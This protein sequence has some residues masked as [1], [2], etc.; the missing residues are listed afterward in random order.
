MTLTHQAPSPQPLSHGAPPCN[1]GALDT[2]KDHENLGTLSV[3]WISATVHGLDAAKGI[4]DFWQSLTGENLDSLPNT[5]GLLGYDFSRRSAL[6]VKYL[7]SLK[8]SDRHFQFTQSSIELIDCEQQRELLACLVGFNAKFTRLDLCVDD[9]SGTLSE[10]RLSKAFNSNNYRSRSQNFQYI[11]SATKDYTGFTFYVGSRS[12][13]SFL[14]IYDKAF[15]S[16]LDFQCTRVEAEL[17]GNQANTQVKL[18]LQVPSCHWNELFIGIIRSIVDFV[19]ISFD[20]NKSRCPLLSWWHKFCGDAMK[21]RLT[22]KKEIPSIEPILDWVSKQFGSTI[23]FFKQYFGEDEAYYL[24]DT[25]SESFKGRL[26][27]RQKFILET[28]PG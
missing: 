6:G 3:S 18:L 4:I 20:T 19:D 17:K 10:K 11:R 2:S 5:K 22:V 8:R 13:E 14:R 28:K 27:P 16:D 12:S 7:F 24:L 9:L 15:E 25:I 21:F 1:T 23:Q 26:N